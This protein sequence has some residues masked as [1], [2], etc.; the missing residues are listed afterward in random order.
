MQRR[1][2]PPDALFDAALHPERADEIAEMGLEIIARPGTAAPASHVPGM[3]AISR[4]ERRLAVVKEVHRVAASRAVL[5]AEG[6]PCEG[7][8]DGVFIEVDSELGGRR[9]LKITGHRP[10]M[11]AR[12]VVLMRE[13]PPPRRMPAPIRQ[14]Q[15][16]E[17]DPTS[18]AALLAAAYALRRRR[19][20]TV[21]EDYLRS[22][23]EPGSGTSPI[24]ADLQNAVAELDRR[25]AAVPAGQ[26]RSAAMSSAA[27]AIAAGL[28]SA[29]ERAFIL[30]TQRS[31]L[32]LLEPADRDRYLPFA[33]QAGDFPGGPSGPNE[34]RADQMF[35]ALT[36]L[37]PE[38]RANSG[39]TA[40]VRADEFTA[41]MQRRI[42]GALVAVPGESGKRL[43]RDASAAFVEMRT[44]A[45]ADGVT[46]GI[47]NSYRTAA[48]AQANAA[49]ADNRSA[50]ASFSSH[51]LGLAVD[52][53]M[54]H[55]GLRFL[56]TTTRPF[57]NV[58]DMYKSPVHKWMFLRG[59]PFGWFPYRKEP[60]H[61]EYN[62]VG[63]RERLRQPSSGTAAAP[64]SAAATPSTP[65]PT[66][67]AAPAAAPPS[68]AP[69][70][71][72]DVGA[73][74]SI[75]DP[76]PAPRPPL[77][78]TGTVGRGGRNQADDVRAVQDRLLALRVA[79]AADIA[80]ERPAAGAAVTEA[81]LPK[82]I[83]AIEAFQQQMAIAVNGAVALRGA[84]RR[85]LDRAIPVP[86]QAELSAI[87]TGLGTI[88]QTVSRG[89]TIAG[90]VGAVATGN[91]AEDVR[92]VQRRLVDLGVLAA[93]HRESP[94]ADATGSVAQANLSATIAALW[95]VQEDARFFV[96]KGTISGAVTAGVVRPG[97]ATATLLDRISVYQ[98]TLGATRLS[99]RDHVRSSYTQ[100]VAGVS[101][102]GTASPSALP[103]ATYTDVD[104]STTP[105]AARNQ[106]AALKL[107]ST[108]EGNFD[109]INT[110]DR[111]VVSVGFIQFAGGGRG[112]PPYIALLKARQP[113]KFRDLL[114]KFGIDVE[115]TVAGGAI[116]APQLVVLDPAGTRVL[117]GDAAERAIRDDKRLTTA[118]ILSGRDRDAQIVQ[119]E[120]AVRGYVRPPLNETVTWSDG[121]VRHKL[122]D[123]L[124]S[125][126]GMAALFDRTI[127][128]GLGAAHRRFQRVIQRMV[129]NAE[130]RST[131]TPPSPPPVT[132]LATVQS[133][134]GDILA[135]L[136][137]DLQAA[138]DVSAAIGRARTLLETLIRAAGAAGATV[139]ALLARAELA[140]ARRAVTDAQVKA[141]DVVNL[142]TSGN[143][144]TRLTTMTTTIANEERRLALTPAPA[145]VADLTAA[146]TA[147][148]Q[149]L[150]GIAGPVSTAPTFLARIQRIRR[151]TLDAGLAEAA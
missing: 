53:N 60:W 135:E 108:F 43:H 15:F 103:L 45:A 106:A 85:D 129:H 139:A 130:P 112:L 14:R 138:T 107:V 140:D 105:A 146:L 94:A 37:R 151:S 68:P 24:A 27:D 73:A 98:M 132:T 29:A 55:S 141:A 13:Q 118:L 41:A 39:D 1:T 2:L 88:G 4:G 76:I 11:M 40:V 32:E 117:R 36:R 67:S 38:R 78:I 79:D 125:Q 145:S 34:A 148:R 66:T 81:A 48:T 101:F 111:A 77:A 35:N 114:Q 30:D 26:D 89:L 70:T 104:P 61:W 122:G 16:A 123:V 59:E 22:L 33:W 25:L 7:H 23:L 97:D 54:S 137:R 128:E 63:F 143:V 87:A 100:S 52:L 18:L 51:T 65:A 3:F 6:I 57:R 93:S 116:A 69:A 74:E 95:R 121:R 50:V 131:T 20:R 92:A 127:Q 31:T 75:T 133:R 115:Y 96:A 58:V 10:G 17:D 110:Y 21:G 71:R 42:D 83:A 120:A 47:N 124:R 64:T 136:E 113:A 9:G 134:E 82:T 49:R 5:E 91:A 126:K 109:A 72:E 150:V 86:T 149:A 8:S 62:P 144:D 46:L 119:L 99:L 19:Q 56:E 102:S 12:H 90:P 147:S 84:T 142:S 28:L 80:A 44:A